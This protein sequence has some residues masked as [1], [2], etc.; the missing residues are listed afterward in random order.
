MKK[1]FEFTGNEMAEAL[2]N[3]VKPDLK[4]GEY[5]STFIVLKNPNAPNGVQ[6]Q[7]IVEEANRDEPT[8]L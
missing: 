3:Y 1:I 6:M 4:Q 8:D 5:N 7:L 2:F